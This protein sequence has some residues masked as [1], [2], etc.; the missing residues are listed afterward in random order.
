ME[1]VYYLIAPPMIIA[2][3]IVI[4]ELIDFIMYGVY[5]QV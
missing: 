5:R 1:A 2:G 3:I 4:G